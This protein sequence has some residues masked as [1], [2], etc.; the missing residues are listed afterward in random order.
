MGG[1]LRMSV[2]R[3]QKT[4]LSKENDAIA[5]QICRLI[6]MRCSFKHLCVSVPQGYLHVACNSS[7]GKVWLIGCI[8]AI[9]N[10]RRQECRIASKQLWPWAFS[11]LSQ[12]VAN[13]KKLFTLKN[14]WLLNSQQLSTKIL[15]GRAFLPAPHSATKA[16]NPLFIRGKQC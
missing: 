11:W 6:R 7:M 5:S 14:Q 12:H 4:S 13:K 8:G 10:S 9:G 3:V 2:F 15:S 16:Y 1:I